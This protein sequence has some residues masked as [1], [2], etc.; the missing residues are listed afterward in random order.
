MHVLLAGGGTAGHIEP[1]M[2]LADALRRRDPGVGITALGTATGMENTLVPARGYELRH[3][4]RVPMPRR[5]TADLL[6]LPG[7]LRA[8]VRTAGTFIELA[9]ARRALTGP[10]CCRS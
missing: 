2:A 1:A 5:P 4:P 9:S 10:A 6:R 3:V 8:A 7:R